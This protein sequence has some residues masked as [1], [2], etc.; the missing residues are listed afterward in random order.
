MLRT[1]REKA[2]EAPSTFE[3]ATSYSHL[4]IAYPDV[5]QRDKRNQ[6]SNDVPPDTAYQRVCDTEYTQ[7]DCHHT[8]SNQ[9]QR[10]ESIPTRECEVPADVSLF[11]RR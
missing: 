6:R 7:A 9:R 2:H 8:A 5:Y 4:V 3:V 10:G 1:A 11:S